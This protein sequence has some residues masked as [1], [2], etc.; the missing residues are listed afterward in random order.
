MDPAT[1]KPFREGPGWVE[2]EMNADPNSNRDETPTRSAA[3]KMPRI[4]RQTT[5]AAAAVPH[6][7]TDTVVPRPRA[8]RRPPRLAHPRPDGGGFFFF[9]EL[10]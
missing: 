3:E 5:V 2:K 7:R 10:S 1:G 9:V 6:V 8:R 4:H